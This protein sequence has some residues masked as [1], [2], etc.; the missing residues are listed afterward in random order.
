MCAECNDR[1]AEGL[2]GGTWNR[3][4]AEGLIDRA[5]SMSPSVKTSAAKLRTFQNAELLHR[6]MR[7][8]ERCAHL[9]QCARS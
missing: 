3:V 2:I 4:G 6:G 7:T 1:R 9:H 8:G 5:R